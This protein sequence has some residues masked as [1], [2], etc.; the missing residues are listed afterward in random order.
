MSTVIAFRSGFLKKAER[1]RLEKS[2]EEKIENKKSNKDSNTQR[3]REAM[4][5]VMYLLTEH[6]ECTIP[7]SVYA[8]WI[9]S[10]KD[11]C[12]I[13]AYKK[14]SGF[15]SGDMPEPECTTYSYEEEDEA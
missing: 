15:W 6:R 4:R 9:E 8:A 11:N 13:D 2:R 5:K 1:I 12:I 14:F 7:Q 3:P 10:G